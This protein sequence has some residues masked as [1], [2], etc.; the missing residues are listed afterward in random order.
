MAVT[1]KQHFSG[2]PWRL[3]AGSLPFQ[4][5]AEEKCLSPQAVR[6][7]VAGKQAAQFVA[8][9]RCAAWL[10]HHH[11]RAVVDRRA[12]IIEDP[13]Q[14]SLRPIEE[15]EIV[16]WTPATQRRARNHHDEPCGRQ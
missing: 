13:L 8:K 3:I 2:K 10:E 7:R 4:E 16:Q 9:H 6:T 14:V 1:M 12:K 5:L 11:G 15:P